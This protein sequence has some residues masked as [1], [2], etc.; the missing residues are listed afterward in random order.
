MYGI[1]SSCGSEKVAAILVLLLMLA[2]LPATVFAAPTTV[3]TLDPTLPDGVPPWYVSTPEV[4][5]TPSQSGTLYWW[6]DSGAVTTAV[7]VPEM[8][9]V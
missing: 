4:F 8:T 7:P 2:I 3:I 9:K 1:G 6:V 5:A